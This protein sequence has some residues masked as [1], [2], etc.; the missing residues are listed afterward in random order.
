MVRNPLPEDDDDS[1][2]S[3]PSNAES[4]HYGP[5]DDMATTIPLLKLPA[6]R[7]LPP[8]PMA[9]AEK[10]LS[11]TSIPNYSVRPK[12]PQAEASGSADLKKSR[13]KKRRSRLVLPV[14]I[15]NDGNGVE[16][17]TCPDS[18]AEENIISL[19]FANRLE[20]K[21]QSSGGELR[22]FSLAN[23]KIIEAVGQVS[24]ECRF[25]TGSSSN[26][27]LDCIFQVFNSLAVP[28]IMGNDFLQQTET[29]SKHTDRLFE[30]IVPAM[31]SL[32]VNS[33][34]NSK[35]N[36]ICRL[37][38]YVGCATADTGSDLDLVSPEFAR[39][40]AFS[41]Q[42][43]IEKLEFADCSVGY[44]S[45]FISDAFSVGNVSDV[46]GFLPRGESMELRLHVLE[47]LTS[48][49]LLGQETINDLDIFRSHTD[50]FIPSI[51]RVGESD[52]NIIRHIGTLERLAS[53]IGS[54][55]KDKTRKK[56]STEEVVD[57]DFTVQLN[58]DDQREN[59]R[60]EAA[61]SEI[62]KKTGPERIE[63][64]QHEATRIS[65]F[66][67]SRLGR[68][69]SHLT[70]DTD[71]RRTDLVSGNHN[72]GSSSGG[73][74]GRFVA[75]SPPLSP[76]EIY[77]RNLPSPNSSSASSPYSCNAEYGGSA[78]GETPSVDYSASRIS[79]S[80]SVADRMSID[81]I[82]NPQV[83][84]YVCNFAGCTA[85]AFQTQYLLNSHANVHSSA[86]PHYCSVQGCPRS[87]G[88]KGFKR[89]DEMIRHGFVHDPPG[90]IC[91]FCPD[92]RHKY[93]RPDNLQ[94]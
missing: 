2:L 72:P 55:I 76:N 86:R 6:F 13:T 94:Q 82:T 61:R 69:Q 73:D 58:L 49:I 78:T 89:K 7:R 17:M 85:P 91:P 87:E 45:G 63:A 38:T 42:P 21:I 25:S 90:Y 54:V 1:F 18:G 81:G 8:K 36:L 68:L 47:N 29:L 24:A 39:S 11:A 43:A 64:Q 31:Q 57:V 84:A 83:G 75:T 23:G 71:A 12:P 10:D 30:Q 60:R 48:D 46:E 16:V 5:A 80:T 93:P 28:A 62:E 4:N 53:K 50:S 56:N 22:R 44:T 37:G 32:R 92:R 26:S 88:G 41:I 66:E 52:V 40:R 51:P 35:R 3:V 15:G 70:R 59:A 79:T 27:S 74:D 19:E 67:E 33:I 9:A 65:K 20:L 77:S 14:I 34:G